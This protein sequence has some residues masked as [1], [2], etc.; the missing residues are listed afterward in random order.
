MCELA[1]C[2]LGPYPDDQATPDGRS[3]ASILLGHSLTL[4]RDAVI[5]DMPEGVN[6]IPPWY[7]VVTT[8]ASKLRSVGCPGASRGE[9]RWYYVEYATGERELSDVS[10]GPCWRWH[11]RDPGDP[12]ELTN[13]AGQPAYAVVQAALAQRLNQLKQQRGSG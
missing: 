9:C 2:T 8:A 12:C 4:G 10:N 5:E 3:F 6:A 13:L 1:G 7:A 11:T